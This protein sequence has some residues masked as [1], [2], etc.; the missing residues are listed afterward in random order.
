ML[1]LHEITHVLGFSNLLYELFQTNDTLIQTKAIN[2]IERKLFTGKNVIKYA[3]R[4]FGCDNIEG[5]E[6]ENQ[7][8]SG[9]IGS[10][11]EARIMLGDYMISTDYDEIVISEI[12]LVLLEDTG[13][14]N[15]NYY[16]GGLFRY[17]KGL[18]CDFLNKKCISNNKTNFKREFC[19][20]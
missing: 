17:G 5:I 1:L 4:H 12:S 2:G 15:V 13:W 3:K 8:G 6:L 19:L 10:H 14:Y 18:G 20:T 7:G 16:T 11:W 9:S